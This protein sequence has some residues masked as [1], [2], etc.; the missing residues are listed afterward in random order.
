MRAMKSIKGAELPK[1]LSHSANPVDRACYY[2]NI[3]HERSDVM[4]AATWLKDTK[5]LLT[6]EWGCGRKGDNK[7]PYR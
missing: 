3:H 5:V 6:N 2:K 7:N 4:N 1:A